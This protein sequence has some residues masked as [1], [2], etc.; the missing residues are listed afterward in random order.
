MFRPII[1]EDKGNPAACPA[2]H[3]LLSDG[4]ATVERASREPVGYSRPP[5]RAESLP[6]FIPLTTSRL[7]SS[8]NS[9]VHVTRRDPSMTCR[10]SRL[11]QYFSIKTK[12]YRPT[13]T[14]HPI[15][16]QALRGRTGGPARRR[17]VF[18]PPRPS[19]SRGIMM[20]ERTAWSLSSSM[21]LTNP[22]YHY[23]L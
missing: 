13:I 18:C 3:L 22:Q 11:R 1:D 15:R 4:P 8:Q 10:P 21:E 20:R 6:S 12:I 2:S 17:I 7:E 23:H 19:S 14:N 16:S 5:L 9:P